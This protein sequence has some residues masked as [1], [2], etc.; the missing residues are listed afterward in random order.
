MRLDSIIVGDRVRKDM[1]DIESLAESMKRH[2]LLHPVVVKKDGT[3][4]AGHR[5]LEAAKHLGW[6][7]IPVTTIE[8]E[9][10]LSAERDENEERK[11][12]T[13]SEAV[14]IGRLIEEQHTAKLDATKRERAQANFA[15]RHNSVNHQVVDYQPIGATRETAAKAVGMGPQ[16]YTQAKEIVAAAEADPQQFGDL[17]VR[18][19]ETGNVKGVHREM[20]RRKGKQHRPAALRKLAYPK[21]NREMQRAVDSLDGIC[22]CLRELPVKQLDPS[23]TNEW[24][25]RLK[26]AVT[27]I[28]R[29][30]REIDR[31]KAD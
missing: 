14:A 1:G 3:L 6:E 20:E 15:K 8:V 24:A 9:D 31:V 12:F 16:K 5:R 13:P 29:V 10:L 28:A 21:P 17:A 30:A 23:K 18:M 27:T 25:K 4:V 22:I 2:G 11:N 26:K 7:T 19:D